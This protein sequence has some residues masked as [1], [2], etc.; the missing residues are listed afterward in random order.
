M[1]IPSDHAVAAVVG[2]EVADYAVAGDV[3]KGRRKLKIIFKKA[4]AGRQ[5]M[6]VRLEKNEA[7]KAGPWELAPLG[8]PGVKSR[9]GYIGAVAAAGYR[10]APIT[11]EG[12]AEV[13][14]SFFP[15]KIQ[16]LQQ[17]FR[18]REDKWSLDLTAEALGQSIQADV[19]HLYSLKSGVA[20]GSVLM[21]F[22]VIGSPATAWRV[23]V[24]KGIG[25]IDVTGQ[26]VGR[27]WRREEDTVIVPLSRP[28]LGA[29]TLLLTF[30]QP[31]NASG[32]ALAPGEVRPLGVQGERGIVQVV[33]PLQVNHQSTTDGA[34]LNIDASE[35]PTEF[36]LLSSAPTLGAWQY[37]ARDF[38]IGMEIEWFRPGET[39]DQ[40]VDFQKLS[41]HV[42]RD[43]QWVTDAHIFVKTRGRSALRMMFPAGSVLWEAKVAGEAV[44]ARDDNGVTLVPLPPLTDPNQAVE[45]SLRYGARSESEKRIELAAPKL[46]APVVI[47]EWTVTGDEG[48]QLVPRGGTAD[49]VVPVLAESGWEWLNRNGRAALALVLLGLVT[50]ALTIG[51]MGTLRRVFAVIAGFGMI[52]TTVAWAKTAADTH[53]EAVS[54]LEYAAPVVA[55]DE[56]IS[57]VI[58]NVSA[59]AASFGWVTLVMLL[60]GL[61]ACVAGLVRSERISFAV[62][63]GLVAASL[64]TVRGGTVLFF[65]VVA[66]AAALLILPQTIAVIRAVVRWI[67]KRNAAVN[68]SVGLISILCWMPNEARGADPLLP[69]ESIVHDWE[70]RD[71]HR[72]CSDNPVGHLPSSTTV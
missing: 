34:L 8:F 39:I 67:S 43:G 19:F 25:N 5:L 60:G 51:E 71:G 58:G 3:D 68:A 23:S 63:T 7:A 13:P 32:G 24:P 33:S 36:R 28:L 70:I 30:E 69:A 12:L 4:V 18:L 49:L 35:I 65:A 44:N 9:R 10:L 29:G 47:G 40:V 22:F 15:K 11:T 2:A 64:L 50:A 42:S 38:S 53:S 57:I 17:A 72:S 20:Y 31:M 48:Q 61:V 26:N 55:A 46:D 45:I 1:E 56:A 52:V 41:S 21:N 62:G 6:T 16:G 66:L 37:I 14:L 59:N 54:I 27:D